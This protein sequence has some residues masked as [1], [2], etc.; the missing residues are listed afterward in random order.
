MRMGIGLG[1]GI[2]RSNYAQG[3][4][5]AYSARVVVDGGVTEGGTCV[6][7]VSSLLQ[8]ASLLLVPSGYKG[9]KLYSEIPTNGNGDLTWTRASDAFRTNASGLIQR[10]PWNFAS[11][12]EDFSNAAWSLDGVTISANQIA[13][14]TGTTTA[15]LMT[16][17]GTGQQRIF[18]TYTVV[19]GS[20]YTISIYVKQGTTSNIQIVMPYVGAGPTFTFSTATFNTV[21]GWTSS[22]QTLANGWYRISATQTA[23]STNAG[24]QLVLPS[25][26]SSVY[27]WGAQFDQNTTAQT[28]LPTTDRLN[29]P[30]LSYMYGSCPSV[31]LEPQRTNLALQSETFDNASWTKTNTT[32]TANTTTSPDGTTNADKIVETATNTS[33]FVIQNIA[34]TV[35]ITYN[36][37]FYGKASERGVIQ[38]NNQVNTDFVN[39]DLVNG[40]VGSSTGVTNQQIQSVGNGWYRCSFNYVSTSTSTTGWL[41]LCIVTSASSSRLESYSGNGTNGLFLWGCQFEVGAY[42]T[43]YIPT[44]TA[45]A[46]R[47]ADTATVT[48]VSSLIGQSAG[49]IFWDITDISGTPTSTGNPDFGV[50]NTAF[51]NWIGIT[52]NGFNS[53]FR[54]T[55]RPTTGSIIDYT[56][57]ITRAKACVAWSSAGAVLYVNGT[58]VATSAVNPNFSFDRVDMLGGIISFMTNQF[59]LFTTRLTDAQLATLTTL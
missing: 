29:F 44:T 8:S 21:S 38:W 45:T 41:R 20:Q 28:Y 32:I 10:V 34:T 53:P 15:D 7:A 3:I 1:I 40:V 12:S 19:S 23:T 2:N 24:F 56:A 37:S 33:H 11:Y 14:P 46:T 30:R 49:T 26:G 39:F 57:N 52:T 58:Q 4:F 22:V 48:G 9:G 54:V 5:N 31:L 13:S 16:S 42:S 35:S 17:N 25:N 18:Q 43:T 51:T 59:A 47:V 36:I 27:L 6:D 55:V 50:R